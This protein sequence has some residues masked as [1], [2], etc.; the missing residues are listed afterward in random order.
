MVRI[1]KGFE[2]HRTISVM[3][4]QDCMGELDGASGDRAIQW[5][6]ELK[7][8][9]GCTIKLEVEPDY[10]GDRLNVYSVRLETDAERDARVEAY[11]QS[12][13]ERQRI[14]AKAARDR[15]KKATKLTEAEER[16]LWMKL[17]KKF[18]AKA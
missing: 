3:I 12:E 16:A 10:D 14:T 5:V 17:N 8:E 11:R 13:L 18:G 1:P 9:A 2:D 4:R 6:E 15:K 7:T